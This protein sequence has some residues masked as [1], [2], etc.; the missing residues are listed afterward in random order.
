[1]RMDRMRR[2]MDGM[3]RLRVLTVW[4]ALAALVLAS[5][6]MRA[7]DTTAA[8]EEFRWEEA[9]REVMAL[10]YPQAF[11][12][13]LWAVNGVPFR[14]G[15]RSAPVRPFTR[16]ERLVY[17]VSWGVVHA[18]Y[19]VVTV[20]P[21]P[22]RRQ[23]AMSAC[24]MTNNFVSAFYRVRDCLFGIVDMQGMYPF[25][26]E[27][28]LREGRYKDNRWVLFDHANGLVYTHR[29]KNPRVEAPPF[30]QSLLSVFYYLRT[31]MPQPGDTFTVNC[32][33][34]KRNYPVRFW[35]LKREALKTEVGEFGCV[36]LEPELTGEGRVFTKRDNL[37]LWLTDDERALP[38]L[39][40]VKVKF[41]S[42]SARLVRVDPMY[43]DVAP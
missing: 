20:E 17:E 23:L 32:F 41:G 14:S 27:E 19:G 38:V 8:E 15:L 6:S 12:D 5:A 24:G 9:Q 7:R 13:S 40:R 3:S 35:C 22:A 18:G 31:V 1:M 26:F 25:F 29:E 21:D 36:L 33:V 4:P 28:H 10:L 16:G 11:R 43:A 42:V 34:Q 2:N 37:R 39:L 30:S